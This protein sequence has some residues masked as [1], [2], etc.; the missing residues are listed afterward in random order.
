MQVEFIP[1][2]CWTYE[3]ML[4]SCLRL[5]EEFEQLVRSAAFT[6]IE[7]EKDKGEAQMP[8]SIEK[9]G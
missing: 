1:R 9:P 4:F 2:S 3:N 6:L 8:P 5:S 7:G